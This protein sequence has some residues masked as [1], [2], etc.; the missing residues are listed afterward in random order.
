MGRSRL[1][2]S[3]GGRL[4]NMETKR[5]PKGVPHPVSGYVFATD[6]FYE[7]R[8]D[9]T[10]NRMKCNHCG[11]IALWKRRQPKPKS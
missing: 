1:D 3:C 8:V 11:R 9:P 4:Q 10:V 7:D 5:L 6:V 2:C